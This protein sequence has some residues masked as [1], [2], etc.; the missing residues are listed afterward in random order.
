MGKWRSE[1]HYYSNQDLLQTNKIQEIFS[2]VEMSN[3]TRKAKSVPT[4]HL[5]SLDR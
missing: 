2:N 1:D 3:I 5:V 4:K